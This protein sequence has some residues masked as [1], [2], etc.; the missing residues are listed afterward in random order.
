MRQV[1]ALFLIPLLN[2]GLAWNAERTASATNLDIWL[3]RD[4]IQDLSK[5]N[6]ADREQATQRLIALGT[7]VIPEIKEAADGAHLDAET[8]ERLNRVSRDA[9]YAHLTTVSAAT[10][11]YERLIG[12]IASLNPRD[13]SARIEQCRAHADRVLERVEA[14]VPADQRNRILADLL[15]VSGGRLFRSRFCD[16]QTPA[17]HYAINDL[18]LSLYC[19]GQILERHPHEPAAEEGQRR[20]ATL[21]G[22]ARWMESSSFE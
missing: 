17:L 8:Q 19:Y 1:L 22:S 13:A 3:V 16:R 10:A 18:Q 20:T 2:C 7:A 15:S 5:D 6:F 21:L 12:E 14:M 4:L 9:Y 11:E